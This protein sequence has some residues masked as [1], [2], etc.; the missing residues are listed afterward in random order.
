MNSALGAISSCIYLR[1]A[2]LIA[3]KLADRN[4]WG[5]FKGNPALERRRILSESVSTCQAEKARISEGFEVFYGKTL[6][7]FTENPLPDCGK[8]KR[9][10]A[11]DGRDQAARR[12][13]VGEFLISSSFKM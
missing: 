7:F 11:P 6:S 8:P 3:V 1:G 13:T 4:A 12:R 5:K 10:A 9:P 2:K